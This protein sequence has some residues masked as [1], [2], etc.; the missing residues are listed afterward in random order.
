MIQWFTAV[1]VEQSVSPHM[2]TQNLFYYKEEAAQKK[3]IY[4][5]SAMAFYYDA[6]TN[7]YFY[8]SESL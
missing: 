1:N 2:W 3:C 8:S 4:S 6:D 5:S 7:F